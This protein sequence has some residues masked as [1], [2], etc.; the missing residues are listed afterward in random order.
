MSAEPTRFYR[1]KG[2][3]LVVTDGSVVPVRDRRGRPA[4][5]VQTYYVTGGRAGLLW[6][7]QLTPLN[8]RE[9][10]RSAQTGSR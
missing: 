2:G 4:F 6:L 9:V 1:T 5:K 3:V 8:A 10:D 7:D